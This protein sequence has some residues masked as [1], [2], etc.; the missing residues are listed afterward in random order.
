[1]P[2]LLPEFGP[3]TG[4][5]NKDCAL[6]KDLGFTFHLAR[7]T[8]TLQEVTDDQGFQ[9]EGDKKTA[10]KFK[11]GGQIVCVQYLERL[12]IDSPN[13]FELGVGKDM[14][15]LFVNVKSLRKVDVEWL[16]AKELPGAV[17]A[18]PRTRRAR[19][20]AAR[21][22][23]QSSKITRVYISDETLL[24]AHEA[25]EAFEAKQPAGRWEEG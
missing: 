18:G 11:K 12:P 14:T 17:R 3:E 20:G 13:H 8:E 25:I 10:A 16:N 24:S 1:M 21:R 22:G 23:D 7:L 9:N 4:V 15:E 6:G 19:R 2:Q 5:L